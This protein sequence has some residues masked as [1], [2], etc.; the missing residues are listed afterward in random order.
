MQPAS[1][2][3]EDV[4]DSAGSVEL[5]EKLY[6][7]GVRFGDGSPV[8]VSPSIHRGRDELGHCVQTRGHCGYQRTLG[9][10]RIAYCKAHQFLAS[11][12]FHKPKPSA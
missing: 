2:M 9:I 7:H 1:A 8:Q 11:A 12:F 3:L 10:T 5:Q 6:P 4:V